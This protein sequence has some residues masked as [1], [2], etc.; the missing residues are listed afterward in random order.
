LTGITISVNTDPGECGAIVNYILPANNCTGTLTCEP[1]PGTFF[2][3]GTTV[4]NCLNDAPTPCSFNFNIQVNNRNPVPT[5]TA[6]ASG[7]LYTVGSTVNFSGSFTDD[8]G[9]PHLS[10]WS[11]VSGPNSATEDGTLIE[12]TGTSGTVAASH[13]FNTVGV[14]LVTLSVS[15][16]CGGTGTANTVSPDSLTAMVVIYDPSGGFVTGGGWINSPAGAY[17]A[18][19]AL[20]GRLSFGINAKYQNNSTIPTGQ[21]EAQF[22][23]GNLSF[24]STGYDWLIIT[25]NKAQFS[26]SGTINGNG[27]YGFTVTVI[28]GNGSGTDKFR[29]K[30]WDRNNGNAVVYDAQPGA[31]DNDPPTTPLGGGSTV[32]H[33]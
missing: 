11:F 2:P 28:D 16:K 31:S 7:A 13:T 26:G 17:V 27:N 20:T 12:T 14:Y 18:N 21:T 33:Q 4:V 3:V 10:Q 15:D 22:R 29:I 30:I 8:V 1:P 24:H 6:P 5:I 19:P 9:T 25:G 32:I 23:D